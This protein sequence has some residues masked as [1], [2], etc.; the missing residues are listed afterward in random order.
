MAVAWSPDGRWI[1]TGAKDN[2]AR[3]WDANTG[4]AL[5]TLGGHTNS[6]LTVAFNSDGRLAVTGSADQTARIWELNTGRL[7]QT[8]TGHTGWVLQA[9]FSPDGRRVATGGMDR[10]A[11]L[12]DADTGELQ[13]TMSG[14][15]AGISSLAF[16][17]DGTRLVTTGAGINIVDQGVDPAVLIWDAQTGQRL[18]KLEAHPHRTVAVAFSPDGRRLATGSVDN[19]VRIREAFPWKPEDYAGGAGASFAERLEA[20][21]RRHWQERMQLASGT[22]PLGT[23][24]VAP[25]RRWQDV[26]FSR[27]NLPAE[28]GTKTHPGRPIPPRDPQA[29][30][31]LIDLTACYNATLAESW[32]PVPGLLGLD[33]NLASLPTGVTNLAGVPFDVRGLIRLSRS[34]VNYAIFPQRVDIAVGQKFRRLHVLHGTAY[35]ARDGTR[36]GSYRLRYRDG[37]SAE[38][39]IL[40]GRDVRD[41]LVSRDFSAPDEGTEPVWVG[42]LDSSRPAGPKVQL[43]KS[44]YDNPSP[45]RE[46]VRITFESAMTASGPFLLALTVEP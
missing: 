28:G 24:Q 10:T 11:R 39:P 46:V 16:S 30:A 26:Y 1:L 38:L 15:R 6:V 7:L 31:N 14:H 45:E 12:W 27:M 4:T 5:R 21:K 32:Q 37:G 41:L 19:T 20:Y 2:T 13:F 29:G 40:Y 36:I 25:G 34:A 3:L 8:L 35:R 42:L 23:E 9:A 33:H 44:S 17:P 22:V 18:L 43:F